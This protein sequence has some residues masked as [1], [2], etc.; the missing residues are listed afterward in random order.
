MKARDVMV[1]NVITVSP[2]LDVKTVARLMVANGISALP[3]TD[4]AFNVV[5]IVSEGDLLHRAEIKTERK[6]PWWLEMLMSDEG[7]AMDFVKSHARQVRD[8]MTRDV[9]TAD[10][11]TSLREIAGILEKNGIKRVPI[12][13]QGKLVG[14][15]SRANI[16][17]AFAMSDTTELDADDEQLRRKILDDL[18]RQPW[19]SWPVNVLV[20]DRVAELWGFVPNAAEKDAI[21]VAVESTAGIVAVRDNLRIMRLQS[22]V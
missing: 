22:M 1:T 9:I 12:L 20:K 3:V 16:V 21:R 5:G 10:A 6:Q 2:D 11:D 18:S 4:E 17:Q 15:V 8:V 14:I 13:K 7:R 19:G